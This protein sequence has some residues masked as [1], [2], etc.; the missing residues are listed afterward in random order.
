M[1]LYED[2]G[3]VYKLPGGSQS[4]REG[5][6]KRVGRARE[7]SG[8]TTPI[9]RGGRRDKLDATPSGGGASRRQGRMVGG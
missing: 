2:G 9:A 7:D 5:G 3:V 6:R 8:P 1:L 4:V